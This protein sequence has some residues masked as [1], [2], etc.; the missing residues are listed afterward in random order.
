MFENAWC[1]WHWLPKSYNMLRFVRT[2]Y[3]VFVKVCTTLPSS[4]PR[5]FKIHPKW[6]TSDDLDQ[7][8]LHA[9]CIF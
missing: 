1:M 7:G 4:T 8:P 6:Q 3:Q 9:F 5:L 2:C